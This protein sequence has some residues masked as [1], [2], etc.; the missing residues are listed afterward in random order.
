MNDERAQAE[1][2]AGDAQDA[3]GQWLHWGSLLR[4]GAL[5]AVALLMVW[6][7]LNVNVPS[8]G[9][10][11]DAVGEVRETIEGFGW[12]GLM[13][14]AGAYALVAVTPIPV[15]I[16]AVGAGILF[17]TLA[18]SI[19][20]VFGALLGCWG[21]YWLARGLGRTVVQRLL[22]RRA[23][24]IERH[25]TE[26]GFDAVFLFRLMPGMPYWPVNYGSGA[27][28]VSQRDF[29]VA[30]GMAG[31]PGQVSLVAIGVF[32]VAPSPFNGIVLGAAWLLT[33]VM[34]V[35]SYR[36]LCGTSSRE[37]PGSSFRTE[38]SDA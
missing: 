16:M 38:I 36:S 31:I 25:L 29:L 3:S 6:L 7:V 28:G 11:Q 26:R 2:N 24:T 8:L 34:T 27:F 14:F 20:S 23:G 19:V 30:S 4:T 22:G 37:L 10:A 13:V 32:I 21:A 35:W 12:A 15:T 17:G 18:G 5:L 1:Q 33:L 9:E